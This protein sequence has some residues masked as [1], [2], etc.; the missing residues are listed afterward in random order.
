MRRNVLF[1]M[2]LACG[3]GVASVASSFAAQQP[4]QTNPNVPANAQ[5]A[6]AQ[7]G[8]RV[9]SQQP[10]AAN[11]AAQAQANRA[12]SA[13]NT[14]ARR[15]ATGYRRYSYQPG[16]SFYRGRNGGNGFD[17]VIRYAGSKIN[18]DYIP[19]TR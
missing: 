15:P 1:S 10:R 3:L 8:N 7:R 4:A 11:P 13:Q 2:S 19:D 14:V 17:P 6:Q 12:R 18:F 5:T 9:Y 16:G